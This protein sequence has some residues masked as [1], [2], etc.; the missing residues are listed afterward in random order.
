MTPTRWTMSD[1]KCC[2]CEAMNSAIDGECQFCQCEGEQCDRD[3][4]SDPR[5][6]V[7]TYECSDHGENEY[8]LDGCCSMKPSNRYGGQP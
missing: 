3:N 7:P 4:C 5:H 2:A 8:P 1:W 6:P